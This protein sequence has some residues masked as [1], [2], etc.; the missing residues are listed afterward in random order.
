MFESFLTAF[1]VYFV[2]VDPIGNAPVFVA[3]TAQMDR[4]RIT[5]T[6]IEATI[7]ATIIML[8]FALCGS[9]VLHY[10]QIGQPA[11]KIAGGLILFLVAW[12]MLNSKR[13]MR[14]H[15]ETRKHHK[16]A[17]TPKAEASQTSGTEAEKR[18]ADGDN[19]AV[20][21]LATPLLAGPAAI[22][23]AMVISADFSDSMASML[24]GYAALLTVMVITGI[25]LSL[26]GIAERWIDPRVT[27]VFSRITAIILA[28]LSVQYIVD[29]LTALGIVTAPV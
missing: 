29:G 20:F 8:F 7:V 12:D 4:A 3:V 15:R 1:V 21:P 11:F 10:L 17:P 14:K 5:R 13:Q 24:T 2:V 9:W 23:S 6:A 26:T 18:D 28:A 27:N 19:V 22:M 16:A 25:V